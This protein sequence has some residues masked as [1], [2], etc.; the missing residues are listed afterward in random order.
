MNSFNSHPV[1]VQLGLW[2]LRK[3]KSSRDEYR[4]TWLE[5]ERGSMEAFGDYDETLSPL[6]KYL[7]RA[8][9]RDAGLRNIEGD[10]PG[11]FHQWYH[12]GER[13]GARIILDDCSDAPNLRI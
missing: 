8:D 9:G 3:E 5:V 13:M 2:G 6:Q 11:A 4:H 1:A 12:N 7:E 10:S